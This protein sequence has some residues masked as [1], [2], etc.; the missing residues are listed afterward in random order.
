M[1]CSAPPTIAKVALAMAVG[2]I[3]CLEP[4]HAS[5][6]MIPLSEV[7]RSPEQMPYIAKRCASIS[8][9]ISHKMAQ[10]DNEASAESMKAY[11]YWS[12]KIMTFYVALSII[13]NTDYPHEKINTAISDIE[14]IYHLY[15]KEMDD[16]YLRTGNQVSSLIEEDAELCIDVFKIAQEQERIDPDQKSGSHNAE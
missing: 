2:A 6:K 1:I 8:L 11:S 12:G 4:V 16:N 13:N 7:Q 14:S 9:L 10:Y 15:N 3:A 5:S